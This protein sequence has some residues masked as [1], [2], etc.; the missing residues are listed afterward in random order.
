MDIVRYR[1]D[2]SSVIDS[3]IESVFNEFSSFLNNDI[4]PI[5]DIRKYVYPKC[6][7]ID[8]GDSVK[9]VIAVPGMN[10]ENVSI[11]VDDDKLTISGQKMTDSNKKYIW[12][13][14]KT[15]AFSRTFKLN[16]D[17]IDIEK[18]DAKFQNGMLE[19]TLP[20][21]EKQKKKS[22]VIDIK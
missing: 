14:L 10:K 7:I 8:E 1:N 15:S 21:T 13:E 19:I 3:Y 2:V 18:I 17:M 11:R 16:T 4:L 6:D 5:K 9:L 22:K 20:Y 12:K